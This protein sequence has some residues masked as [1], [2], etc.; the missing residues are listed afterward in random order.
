MSLDLSG[1]TKD[2]ILTDIGVLGYDGRE[3]AVA[4]LAE[5]LSSVWM[6]VRGIEAALATERDRICNLSNEIT[7]IP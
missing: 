6:A 4:K 2:D 5:R 3:E 1:W 7:H